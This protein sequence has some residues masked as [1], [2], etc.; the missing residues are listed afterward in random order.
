MPLGGIL[1]RTGAWHGLVSRLIIAAHSSEA[2]KLREALAASERA[3]A[4]A[5]L[6]LEQRES[7]V[8]C[9]KCGG[10]VNWRPGPAKATG[11]Q[12]STSA[13]PLGGGFPM[14]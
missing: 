7:E 13:I 6:A 12:S 10:R 8:R 3:S 4:E 11:N 9:T 14:A 1:G 5:K 2:G